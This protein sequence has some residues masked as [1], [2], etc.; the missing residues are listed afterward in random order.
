MDHN[1]G[2]S[3]KASKLQK[4]RE[5]KHKIPK[6]F[7]WSKHNEKCRQMDALGPGRKQDTGGTMEGISKEGTQRQEEAFITTRQGKMKLRLKFQ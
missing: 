6:I 2:I 1:Q 4:E 7:K 5:Q 3:P